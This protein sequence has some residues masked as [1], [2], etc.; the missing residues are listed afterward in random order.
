MIRAI[1]GWNNPETE[2][3]KQNWVKSVCLLRYAKHLSMLVS[4]SDYKRCGCNG[5]SGSQGNA[6]SVFVLLVTR[7]L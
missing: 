3:D 6:S 5:G 7:D 4:E 1:Q 2:S